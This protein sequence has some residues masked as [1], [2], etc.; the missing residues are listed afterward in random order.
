MNSKFPKKGRDW[1]ALQTQMTEMS[2]NDLDWQHGRHSAFVWHANDEVKAVSRRAYAMFIS[3]NGLGKIVF[4]SILTMEQEVVAMVLSNLNGDG[5]AGHMTSGG[6]ESIFLAVKAAREWARE[7]KPEIAQ[8]EIIA[9]FSA[10]PALNKSA[11]Y[12][13]MKVVRIPTRADFRA[14]VDAISGAVNKNT[15][16]LYGSAPTFSMGVIDPV[17]DLGQLA[18]KNDLWLHVDGCVGGILGPFV[19]KAGYPVPDFDYSLPGVASISADLHKS[20]FTAKGASVITFRNQELQAYTRYDFEDWPSGLYS[21]LTFTGTNP[22]GAIAAAWAVMNFLGEEGYIELA[23][24]SMQTRE[25]LEKGLAGING[26]KVW[27]APDLWAVAYGSDAY[28]ILAVTHKM[29]ERGWMVAPNSDPPGIHFMA[30]PVHA[31]F[32]DEYLNALKESVADVSGGDTPD[33]PVEVRYA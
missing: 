16:M 7:K 5:A 8:P 3:T 32:V 17:S 27:G 15:I 11:H 33:G 6:T 10:H 1:E 2:Q 31:P 26:I 14:D 28:D 23:R 29:W 22:G 24:I 18:Q 13:G 4:P 30:T 25:K 19:R 21:S 9:P 12:L 20:G